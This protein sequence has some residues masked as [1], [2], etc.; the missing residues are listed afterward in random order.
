MSVL[1]GNV[2]FEVPTNFPKGNNQNAIGYIDLQLRISPETQT[3]IL[4]LRSISAWVVIQAL[5]VVGIVQREHVGGER[6]A[7]GADPEEQRQH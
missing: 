7:P 4:D 1:L 6:K 2:E 5:G 3:G